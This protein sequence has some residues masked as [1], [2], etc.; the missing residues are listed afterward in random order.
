MRQSCRISGLKNNFWPECNSLNLAF[1]KCQVLVLCQVPGARCQMEVG[2]VG[3]LKVR[4]SYIKVSSAMGR[5]RN[6]DSHL[7]KEAFLPH[8]FYLVRAQDWGRESR[9]RGILYQV[10][11][12]N[13]D[14]VGKKNGTILH[15]NV[16]EIPK[17]IFWTS[18]ICSF[19]LELHSVHIITQL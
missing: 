4:K 10:T 6:Y 1:L 14:W 8:L 17:S 12:S 13:I 9:E 11:F 15:L 18:L 16:F 2:Y 5:S 3:S 7:K 19:M